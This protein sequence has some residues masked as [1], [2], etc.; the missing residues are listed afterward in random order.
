MNDENILNDLF[1]KIKSF[2]GL[3]IEDAHR[4]YLKNYIKRRSEDS[5]MSLT[6][7]ESFILTDPEQFSQ[8]INTAAINET[9]FF[10]EEIQFDFLRDYFFNLKKTEPLQ[11]WSASCSS[12]QEPLSVYALCKACSIKADIHASDIDSGMLEKFRS[13]V[14][15]KTSLRTDGKKYHRLISFISDSDGEFLHIHKDVLNDINI[16][17]NNLMEQNNSFFIPQ[18]LDII[19]IR[20]TFIYFDTDTRKNLLE[21]MSGLLK[22]NGLLFVSVNEIASIEVTPQMNLRKEH[23][24][25]IYYLKK[26]SFSCTES[27][28]SAP[29]PKIK[30]AGAPE[31]KPEPE[32]EPEAGVTDFS[33]HKAAVAPTPELMSKPKHRHDSS[34]TV[35]DF[36]KSF[37]QAIDSH[38][39]SAAELILENLSP[40]I[41]GTEY[42]FYFRG[43]LFSLN[44]NHEEAKN[45]FIKSTIINP[46]FWP[47][48]FQLALSYGKCGNSVKKRNTFEQCYKI[49]KKSEEKENSCYNF[50]VESFSP[51]YFLNL[52]L[53]YM[54][55]DE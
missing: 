6:D 40:D 7:F 17:Y 53:K 9:Y 27:L 37:F 2:S 54:E 4:I 25:D 8:I 55:T 48:F 45:Q 34:E 14:F 1:E 19:F 15:S 50:I 52:C 26:V 33:A 42:E 32:S 22:E 44:E 28:A 36:A 47:G 31:Q 18:S 46:D 10:R 35:K 16:F 13:G 51:S 39:Y 12:G 29:E 38:N 21:Y 11:I 43:L 41:L 20:N 24:G 49:I 3:T 30:A 5:G 23:T